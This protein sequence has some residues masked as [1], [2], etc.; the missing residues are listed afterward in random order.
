MVV[1]GMSSNDCLTANEKLY[2]L[3]T[4]CR[5][6]NIK[7]PQLTL[8]TPLEIFEKSLRVVITNS[9][10]FDL[11]DV[12]DKFNSAVLPNAMVRR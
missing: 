7:L 8:Q 12:V 9:D 5:N 1:V 2:N 10:D 3:N 4:V 6:K 11:D